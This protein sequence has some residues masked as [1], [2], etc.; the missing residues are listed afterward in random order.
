[1]DNEYSYLWCKP[2]REVA[3][4]LNTEDWRLNRGGWITILLWIRGWYVFVV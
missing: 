2:E 3:H 1:L 4:K